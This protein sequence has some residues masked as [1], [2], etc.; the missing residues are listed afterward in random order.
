MLDFTFRLKKSKQI[1]VHLIYWQLGSCL[2]ITIAE[3]FLRGISSALYLLNSIHLILDSDFSFISCYI[4]IFAFYMFVCFEDF[5]SIL[6]KSKFHLLS[7]D[8]DLFNSRNSL[9]YFW[10][11]FSF[12]ASCKQQKT[13]GFLVF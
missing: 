10:L 4:Y 1:F 8:S 12:Y 5:I 9:T 13:K 7:F 6:Q 3:I 11:M 2:K